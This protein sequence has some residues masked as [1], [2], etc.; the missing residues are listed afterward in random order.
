MNEP[1]LNKIK[2]DA[3]LAERKRLIEKARN[4]FWCKFKPS[5]YEPLTDKDFEDS[6]DAK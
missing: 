1:I 5:G 2:T 4:N 6:K 3:T